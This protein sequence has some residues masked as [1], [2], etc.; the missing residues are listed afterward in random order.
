MPPNKDKLRGP[1]GKYVSARER[2]QLMEEGLIS[3]SKSKVRKVEWDEEEKD[4]ECYDM[5]DGKPVHVNI[6]KEIAFDKPT[7]AL[8]PNRSEGD[9]IN[10]NGETGE[11]DANISLRRSNRI[12]KPMERLGNAPYF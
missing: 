8:L 10:N 1:G 6:D 5:S 7:L 9:K 11:G 3:E 4:F 2:A 12:F